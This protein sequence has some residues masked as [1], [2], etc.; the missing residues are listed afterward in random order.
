MGNYVPI[1]RLSR[2]MKQHIHSFILFY[3]VFS[4]IIADGRR[5]KGRNNTLTRYEKRIVMVI[6][7]YIMYHHS[8]STYKI[9]IMLAEVI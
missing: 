4:W 2:R 9:T 7:D 1:Q 3:S 5:K 6:D 8:N